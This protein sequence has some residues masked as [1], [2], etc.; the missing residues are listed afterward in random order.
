A[1]EETS[2][3]EQI[4]GEGFHIDRTWLK[5]SLNEI[6]WSDDTAKTFLAS[7]YK[8]SPQGTLEDV[9]KRLTKEQAGEFVEEIQDRVAQ[10][11]AELFK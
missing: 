1:S 3:D 2:P 5:E 11:Q 9:I 7:Q 4:E 10:I 6:K 8:V